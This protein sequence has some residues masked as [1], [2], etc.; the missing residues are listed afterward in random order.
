MFLI[1]LILFLFFL[2]AAFSIDVII[3]VDFFLL[4]YARQSKNWIK[5]QTGSGNFGI[6]AQYVSTSTGYQNRFW[7]FGNSS[8]GYTDCKV[9]FK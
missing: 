3:A 5:F 9:G 4:S 6:S 8:K 1:Y 2:L 7:R